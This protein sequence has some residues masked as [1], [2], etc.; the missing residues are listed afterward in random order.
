MGKNIYIHGTEGDEQERLATLNSM[1]N[2]SFVSFL[3]LR[4]TDKVLEVGS[5][6]GL[7]AKE[8]AL[9]IPNGQVTGLEKSADQLKKCPSGL[10]NLDFIKGDAHNMPFRNNSFDVVYCRYILEHVA[11]P[12]KVLNEVWRVLINGGRL[13]VQEN[14]ILAIEIYPECPHF[15]KAWQKF[16][17]LQYELGGDALIGK[18]LYSLLKKSSFKK[19]E[20]SPAPEFHYYDLKTFSPWIGNL[21]GNIEGARKKLIDHNL[22][23]EEEISEAI[24]ELRDFITLEDASTYFY[25]NR[26]TACK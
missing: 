24:N 12:L 19:I 15:K 26:A 13:F 14:N 16:A 21:I 25:W 6:L 3:K 10:P 23:T 22:L 1:T 8:A 4:T 7:L 20:L 2:K 5:G 18:K 9:K 11:N 17:L